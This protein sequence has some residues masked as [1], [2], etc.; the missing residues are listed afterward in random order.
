MQTAKR[1]AVTSAL[2]LLS[3]LSLS[4]CATTN[5]DDEFAAINARLTAIEG[6]VQE[7]TA[8]AQSAAEQAQSA[9][10]KADQLNQRVTAL[11]QLVAS[12]HP[13]N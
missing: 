7:N 10:Q 13:R 8:A 3:G 9:N 5:Y 2:I 11:E 6:R 12:K 4:A 1:K